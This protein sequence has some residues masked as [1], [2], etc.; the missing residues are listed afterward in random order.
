MQKRAELF[1]LPQGNL[2][3]TLKDITY[4]P[5]SPRMKEPFTVRGKVELL[6]IPFVMPIWVLAKVTYP[7]EWWEELIPIWGSPTVGESQTALGGDFEIN[8]PKGFER[9]GEFALDVEVHAGPTFSLDKITIPPF[10]PVASEQMTFIVGGEV[11]PEETGFQNFRITGYS[12]NGGPVV[13]PPG[14][15]ELDMGDKCRVHVA[16][17]HRNSAVT[18]K[19][20]AAIWQT[21]LLDPHDEVLDAEKTFSVPSSVDWESWEGSIDIIITS[22][23][24][25]GSEYGLY[26]KIMGITG[27]DIFTEYLTNVITIIG[28]PPEEADIKDFGFKLTKGT[29]NIGDK[30]SFTAPFDYKGIAQDGQLTIEIGT[31]VY[32]TFNRV[33]AYDP[34][35][36]SF[37]VAADWETRG[38]EGNIT[39]PDVLEPGQ[40][41]SVRAKLET[42]TVKTQ[43]TDTDWSAFDIR[44]VAPP[45]SDI[46]NFDFRDEGG[47]YDLGD[48]VGYTAPYEYKGKAQGGWLTISLGTGA[49]P[50][51]FTKHTFARV[52]VSF[53]Q[54]MDWASGQLSGSFTLPTTLEPGQTYNVRAKLET[55]D[56]KQETDT[57]W[58]AF[59]ITAIETRTLEIDV[60]PRGTGYVTTSPAPI[61][62]ENHWEDGDRGKFEVGTRVRVTAHPHSGYEF[63]HWSDEIQGGVSDD[64]PEW[65]S[66]NGYMYDNK[67]VKAHFR[68][69]EVPPEEYEG[70]ISKKQLEYD[71]TKRTIPVSSVPADKRG[72]VHIWGR[73]DMNSNQKMGIWWQVKDP[74]GIVVEEYARWEAYWTGP[75]NAQEFI[76]GRFDLD[77]AGTYTIDVELFM[78]PDDQGCVDDYHGNLCTVAGAPPPT[79][80]TFDVMVWGT[81]GFG[82]YDKWMCFYYDPATSEFVGDNN[83]H[84]PS[85]DIGFSNVEP[86]GY[87]AVYLLEDSTMSDQFTSPSFDAVD[88]GRY[89]YDLD[90]NR[91]SKIG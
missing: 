64:N 87:L 90:L 70:T 17:D 22:A 60:T 66:D 48:R 35:V 49:Y 8:F 9:E 5:E 40:T 86:G 27:G 79:A 42:L 61:D 85:Q 62:I 34:I 74:D 58:S 15:L 73:N 69:E 18:A 63:D 6:K 16:F 47:T 14:V 1:E 11:P 21:A 12:K 72:L 82:H 31:G 26:V 2:L 36:V 81:G 83:W 3:C 71:G 37:P 91:V 59:D 32:P 77:K 50:S 89:Q 45:V 54:A 24:S 84:S 78:N 52:A 13:T 67:A 38:L 43:E 33:Y 25:P 65:V 28:V 44:E 68:E 7:E 4:T 51:F 46:R 75:G 10:P 57:D 88:G 23:I 53:E 41:Y 20:H 30:V 39:L 19:F 56:G 55:A 29:Y 80:V 76:G